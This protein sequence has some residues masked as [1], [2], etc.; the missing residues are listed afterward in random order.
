MKYNASVFKDLGLTMAGNEHPDVGRSESE[1]ERTFKSFFGVHWNLCEIAW[2]LLDDHGKY[3]KREPRHLLWTLV[4]YKVYSTEKVH[5]KI[6]KEPG[7][8]KPAEKTFRIWV[9]KVSEELA[10]LNFLVVRSNDILFLEETLLFLSKK[11]TSTF[12][13]CFYLD[14]FRK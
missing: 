1:K 7:K 10:D 11:C 4:F 13:V 3:K 5:C 12:F 2:T 14:L 8:K 6:V 9:R